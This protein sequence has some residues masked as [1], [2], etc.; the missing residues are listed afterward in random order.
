MIPTIVICLCLTAALPVYGEGRDSAPES[1][2]GEGI[3]GLIERLLRDF[4][5]H[6]DPHMREMERSL[7]AAEPEL[8]RLLGQ[9]RDMVDYHPPEVLPNGD[10]LIRRRHPA[11]DIA[12]PDAEEPDQPA[13]AP[14][15][16]AEGT[17]SPFEL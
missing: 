3:F 1:M 5:D 17:V 13:P 4:V 2:Q 9:L 16:G 7:E 12:D 6:A 8:R 11:P 10:I 14:S 15:E